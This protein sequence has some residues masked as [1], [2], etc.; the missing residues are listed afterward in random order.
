MRVFV[1]LIIGFLIMAVVFTAVIFI[2]D[3]Q[4]QSVNISKIDLNRQPQPVVKSDP[5]GDYILEFF[6]EPSAEIQDTSITD[7]LIDVQPTTENAVFQP[8]SQ[9]NSSNVQLELDK[10]RMLAL[11]HDWIYT[12][13]IE[14]GQTKQGTINKSRENVSFSI[15]EGDELNNGIVISSLNN[16][17]AVLQLGESTFNLRRARPP[18]FYEDVKKTMRPLTPE[19]QEQAYDYYMRVYGDKFKEM[20]KD[21]K[22]P[23]GMPAP[24]RVSQEE[25]KKG[26]ETYWEQ[27]GKN[28]KQESANFKPQF[29]YNQDMREAYEK[30]WMQF[31]NGQEKPSFDEVF[32]N[33]NSSG[34]GSRLVPAEVLQQRQ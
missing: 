13:Y 24:R 25:Q 8:G 10:N 22:P 7:A 9:S 19:E 33:Q 1:F 30:Y 5:G 12:D 34:P 17:M 4:Q 11:I 21:Y 31:G 29:Y 32:S 20:N 2:P 26:L 18:S 27:Y 14:V 15:F 3:S 28:F 6:P 16:N 23:N